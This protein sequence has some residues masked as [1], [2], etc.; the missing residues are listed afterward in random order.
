MIKARL[1]AKVRAQIAERARSCCE[2]CRSQEHYSPDSFVVEHIIPTARKGTNKIDNLAFSCQGCNNR[3]YTHIEAVDPAT[4]ETAPL[5]HPRQ[6]RWADHFAWNEDC[7]LVIGLTPT[8][9]ATVERLQLNR[10]GLLNLRQVLFDL[11]EHPPDF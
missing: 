1:T 6:Q 10:L 2:Y 4:Q 8:G 9:R 7:S 11:N 3:K 5:Y